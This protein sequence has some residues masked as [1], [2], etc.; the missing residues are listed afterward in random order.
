MPTTR[1]LATIL[2][3]TDDGLRLDDVTIGPDQIVA[4][5]EA[6][7]S[8]ATCPICGTWSEAIHSLYRRTIADL[9]WGRQTVRLHLRIRKFFCRQP[10]CSRRVFTERL[11][12]V[13]APYARRTRRFTEV[14]RLLAFALGGEPGARIV[15][16][17]GMAT[18]PATLL[19]L[20]RRTA[21]VEVPTP[22]ALGVDDWAQRKRHTYGTILIDLEQHRMADLLPDRT[23]DTLAAWLQDR[24]GIEIISRDR[25][26]AYADG[27][28][29]GAP[30]AMQVA[31]R[32]HL[33]R[34]LGEVLDRCFNR[35]RGEI[36]EIERPDAPPRT[37]EGSPIPIRPAPPRPSL[38]AAKE[39][40]RA[41][42][43]ERYTLIR[44]RYL[45]GASISELARELKLNWK[46]V[47]KY[48][49]ADQCPERPLRPRRP[50]VLTP[51]EP[52]LLQRWA[53]GCHNGVRLYREI[54]AQ[55]F[56]GSRI[57]V[58]RFVAQLRRDQLADPTTAASAMPV[59][60]Q[61]L[62]PRDATWLVIRPVQ[63]RTLAE[64]AALDRL[65]QLAP[66]LE[67]VVVLGERFL[68]L[69][70]QRP[71]DQACDQWV[72]DAAASGVPELRRFA[73]KLKQDLSAVRAACREAW[74]NGQPEGHV[75]K[76]K[77]LKRSMYGRAKFDLLRLRLLHAA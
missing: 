42:R 2:L 40:T 28:A 55:G 39:R 6:T 7:A 22:R 65:T 12:T 29:R 47:R 21:I 1:T 73:V 41:A 53:E 16:R 3:P 68:V 34:N 5:L 51:Y 54:V 36:E 50:R 70:R 75:H 43:Q 19:R 60:A 66:D 11:P 17:L 67:R 72:T 64:Q 4:T 20:I 26:G 15:E 14:V 74:S 77:L 62:T 44:E 32:F 58:A 48:A 63:E 27:A 8:R 45:K 35:Y 57:H 56:S 52:Y 31:D 61:G 49:Q 9:P 24:S 76:L 18:S 46:T 69:L 59:P 23:A 38:E 13:V 25:R 30:D 10:T 33:T 71:G 37:E